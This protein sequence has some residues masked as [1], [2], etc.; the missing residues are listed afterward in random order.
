MA[1][2]EKTMCCYIVKTNKGQIV[3]KKSL[4]PGD[5]LKI[6][7]A[8]DIKDKKDFTTDKVESIQIY[9]KKPTP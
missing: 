8:L 4:K 9:I 7:E 5:L 2:L 6:A 3:E 1:L